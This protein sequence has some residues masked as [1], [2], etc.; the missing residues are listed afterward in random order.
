VITHYFRDLKTEP[1][2]ISQAPSRLDQT[3]SIVLNAITPYLNHGKKQI[4]VTINHEY[5]YDG[6]TPKSQ[7]FKGVLGTPPSPTMDTSRTALISIKPI[8]PLPGSS[9]LSAINEA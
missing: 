1:L 9:H 7:E 2:E 5:V 4:K 8:D 6:G 3:S